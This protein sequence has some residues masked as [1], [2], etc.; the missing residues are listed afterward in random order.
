MHNQKEIE[1]RGA[2]QT[3][4]AT[5]S[6][7][8][9]YKASDGYTGSTDCNKYAVSILGGYAQSALRYTNNTDYDIYN[10]L[11][12]TRLNWKNQS[13]TDIQLGYGN[14]KYGANSFYTAAWPDQ[15]E[16]TSSYNGS[17]KG[18]FGSDLK[19][20]PIIYWNR[21]L[22]QFDLIK[23]VPWERNYHRGDT[24][25]SNLILQYTSSLGVTSFGG[26]WRKE[27]ITSSKLGK[28]MANPK[29]NYKAYDDRI[30][31]SATLE[32]TLQLIDKW[33]LSAGV[34]MNHNTFISGEYGFYPSVSAAYRPVESLKIATSWSKSTRMP[35][36]TELYYNTETHQANEN[37]KPE[38][39]ESVDLSLNYRTPLFD[40]NLTGFLLWGRDMIDWIKVTAADKPASS[41]LTK[42]NTQ[43]IEGN[44]R[45]HLFQLFPA[46]GEKS[47]LVVGYTRLFQ[48]YDTGGHIS[49][50]ANALNYL[51]DKFA[52]QLNHEISGGF[53]A[54]WYFRF[55]K[56]MGTYEKF[57]AYQSTGRFELYPAFSTLDLRLNYR[58]K[59]WELH[60]SANNLY[61]T[62]YFDWGNIPQPGFWLQGG[63][64]LT[65]R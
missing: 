11:W 27:D 12:Q 47:A 50:S 6:L 32:H 46:L 13:K 45:L 59:D 9:G 56:R 57:E 14:K 62:H 8:V 55:Q 5:H 61:D 37:L 64:A 4:I 42:V 23:D 3:G 38:K 16:H 43:G 60:V 25:G 40:A 44:I 63:I 20:I 53:S 39:S 18:E 35:T 22:D 17:I 24:Y 26:E 41:N 7:S 19:V 52:V 1:V 48:D 36:F 30:N 58:Y 29:G 65:I 31:T 51:R 49:Q 10:L 21:H 33:T 34:L 15:Y 54:N 2:A 28:A